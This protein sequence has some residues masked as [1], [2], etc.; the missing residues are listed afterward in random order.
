MKEILSVLLILLST[1]AVAPAQKHVKPRKPARAVPVKP[2]V[3]PTL[4]DSMEVAHAVMVTVE[5]DFGKKIPTIAEA[6]NQIE[7][8]YEPD[9]GKGRTFA[10]LDAYGGPAADGKLLHLSMHVSLEKTGRGSLVFRR[11]GDLL[12][13][14]RIIQGERTAPAVKNLGIMFDDGNGQSLVVDGSHS[15]KSFLDAPV[16]DV[17]RPVRDLWPAGAEREMTFLYSACGCPVKVDVMREGETMKRT[18][19]LPVMF[20]DDP[21]AVK[22][23]NALMKW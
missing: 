3:Y 7:R 11:T 4:R 13:T 17:G 10:I 21:A 14:C 1:I 22:V 6:L 2:R 19:D 9:D 20:P 8:R 23:I 16:R 15:P 12:W 5:L 18:K